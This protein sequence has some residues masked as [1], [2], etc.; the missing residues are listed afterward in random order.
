VKFLSQIDFR[1][2][3]SLTTLNR[4][5]LAFTDNLQA[6]TKEGD[7]HYELCSVQFWTEDIGKPGSAAP[8]KIERK[9][10]AAFSANHYF[11]QAPL[12][13]QVHVDLL[14]QFEE[15]LKQS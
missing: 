15:I 14:N 8:V 2:D 6:S 13:T 4:R 10:S 1:S 11:S 5:L 3:V 9:I 12:M 7:Q